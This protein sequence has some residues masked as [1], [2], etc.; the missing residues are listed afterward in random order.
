MS[1]SNLGAGGSQPVNG[2]IQQPQIRDVQAIVN[3]NDSYDIDALKTFS[4]AQSLEYEKQHPELF[5]PKPSK[6]Q[7]ETERAEKQIEPE[8]IA[9][10]AD[11]DSEEEPIPEG[12]NTEG[13]EAKESSDEPEELLAEEMEKVDHRKYV[14]AKDG[15]KSLKI[16]KGA[17]VDIK[18]DG[19]IETVPLKEILNRASGAIH[20]EKETSRLGRERKAL[21]VERNQWQ[22]KAQ[23]VK[24]N[25]DTLQELIANSGPE[26][27]AAYFAHLKGEDPNVMFNSIIQNA[28]KYAEQFKDLT[29]RE[30]QLLNENRKYKLNQIIASKKAATAETKQAQEAERQQMVEE[31]RKRNIS[32]EDW[33]KY[34]AEMLARAKS[35]EIDPDVSSPKDVFDYID[36]RKRE[37]K[38]ESAITSVNK[39]L[40]RDSE[41]KTRVAE[42]VVVIEASRRRVMSPDEI[43]SLVKFAAKENNVA[44]SDALNQKAA[45]VS[46][47]GHAISQNGKSP[48]P[49]IDEGPYT[50]REHWDKLR[51]A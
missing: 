17:M 40:L 46:K 38:V 3:G 24:E 39:A 7:K 5:K 11:D 42:A 25:M 21:E 41:F 51:G 33:N 28:L 43:K 48:K 36:G 47:S 35:G 45:R 13:E 8:E 12:G 49:K 27:V 14:V 9:G 26:E 44:L 23:T 4:E 16:P 10:E 19:K 6:K 30:I 2:A 31:M 20:I 34:T 37:I 1:D 22:Q 50:L 32:P 15:E 18:V 29:E